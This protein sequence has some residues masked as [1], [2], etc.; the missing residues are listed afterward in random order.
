VTVHDPKSLKNRLEQLGEELPFEVTSRPMMGGSTGGLGV[1][2]FPPD[3]ERALDQPGAARMRHSPE[4]PESKSYITFSEADTADDDFM[5]E[6][7]LLAA[8][9]APTKKKR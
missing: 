1:K 3:R 6:W 8:Q 2:L 4:Q 7:L 5:I 9:S